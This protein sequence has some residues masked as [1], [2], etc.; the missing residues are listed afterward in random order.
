MKKKQ[1]YSIHNV[2]HKG[3]TGD[4]PIVYKFLGYI[5]VFAIVLDVVKN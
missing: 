2:R 1:I 4:T 5:F 3:I